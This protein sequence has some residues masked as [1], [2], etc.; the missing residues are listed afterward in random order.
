MKQQTA[1]TILGFGL[2]AVAVTIGIGYLTN[3]VNARAR[4][5]DASIKGLP[6]QL[7]GR[8]VPGGP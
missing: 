6:D 1:A 2:V 3:Q 4:E 5:L 7:L 8:F